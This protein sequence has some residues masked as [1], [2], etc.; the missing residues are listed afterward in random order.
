MTPRSETKPTRKGGRR[1]R[2]S[3][4]LV[5]QAATDLADEAG[6]EAMTMQRIGQRLGVEAMSLYRHVRNKEDLID[7]MVDLVF[8]EIEVLS[9]VADWRTAMRRR[10]ESTR[11]VLARHPWAVGLMESRSQ[12]GP[13]T[14]RHRDAVLGIL[15]NAGFSSAMATHA[16]NLLDSYVYGSVLQEHSLTMPTPEE[17]EEGLR[18]PASD[19]YPNLKVVGTDLLESGW[20]FGSEFVFGLDLIVDALDR[21][22]RA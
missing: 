10:A 19:E 8:S 20:D 11:E 18:Q 17:M 16:F 22:P 13:V 4:E 21:H 3:R 1:A 2:L 15:R 9:E 7:G 12:P 6:L 5:V 14:L